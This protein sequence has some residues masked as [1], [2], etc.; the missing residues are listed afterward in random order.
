[1]KAPFILHSLAPGAGFPDISLALDDPNGLLAIGGDLSSGRLLQAYRQGIF[2]WYSEGQ[3][4]LWWSPDPRLVLFPSELKISRSLRK[5]IRKGIFQITVNQAFP[6]VI[7]ACAAPRQG[8]GET[9]ITSGMEQAYIQLHRLGWAHSVEAWNEGELVGGFYGVAMG[10]V[11]FGESMFYRMPDAS[12]VAFVVFVRRLQAWGYELVDCQ[13][14]TAH[15]LS[16]GA[17][18][19]SR[20]RFADMLRVWCLEVPDGDPLRNENGSMEGGVE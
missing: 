19:I 17:R 9:W 12:K 11:F 7:R 2:P 20:E 3:P 8:E 15:L 13:V 14:S 10:R 5:T 16:L 4:I 18:E 6:Q 1:M